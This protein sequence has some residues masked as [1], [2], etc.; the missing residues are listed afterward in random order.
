MNIPFIR[1][2]KLD[3]TYDTKDSV[4][5][6]YTKISN[7]GPN[8]TSSGI[9]LDKELTKQITQDNPIKVAS[10][11][12]Y[13]YSGKVTIEA[14]SDSGSG[15]LIPYW[16]SAV[17]SFFSVTG[18]ENPIDGHVYHYTLKAA[19]GLDAS[20]GSGLSSLISYDIFVSAD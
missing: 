7:S 12:N 8:M 15:N 1:N 17:V 13:L 5:T 2:G 4:F 16:R 18:L 3:D 14:I 20:S 11:I 9:Y 19:S 10:F 6:L